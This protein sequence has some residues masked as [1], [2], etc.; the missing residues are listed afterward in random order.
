MEDYFMIS[1][2]PYAYDP[3][4]NYSAPAIPC[5]LSV[6]HHPD[7]LSAMNDYTNRR[8]VVMPTLRSGMQGSLAPWTIHPLRIHGRLHRAGE[9]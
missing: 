2:Y 8:Q 7:A 9:N 5:R 4:Q 1:V 6:E 3:R